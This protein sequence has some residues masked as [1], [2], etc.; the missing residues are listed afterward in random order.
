M[1]NTHLNNATEGAKEGDFTKIV[2][3]IIERDREYQVGFMGQWVI[4]PDEDMRAEDDE[5]NDAGSAW[6]I[7][8][9]KGGKI[10][11]YHFHCNGAWS[12]LKFYDSL[13]EAVNG[14]EPVPQSVAAIASN[15]MGGDFVKMLDV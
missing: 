12:S 5:C 11:A 7:A 10:G 4:S 6:A 9:T 15:R 8:R 2:V 1:R 14:D 3:N 13:E